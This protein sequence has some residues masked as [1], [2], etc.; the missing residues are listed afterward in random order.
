MCAMC[1]RALSEI[2]D[3][4]IPA[5]IAVMQAQLS[6]R[7]LDRWA[8]YFIRSNLQGLCRPCHYTKTCSDKLHT[9]PWADVVERDRLTQKKVWSF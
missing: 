2:C 3:H 6:G 9:G 8:G 7:F 1:N 4:I 5:E